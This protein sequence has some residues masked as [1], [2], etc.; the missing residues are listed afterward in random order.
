MLTKT[1]IFPS[2]GNGTKLKIQSYR[3]E[4]N[5][6][7]WKGDV[8]LSL[9][10]DIWANFYLLT[11][12]YVTWVAQVIGHDV[13]SPKLPNFLG[14]GHIRPKFAQISAYSFR[15]QI[16]MRISGQTFCFI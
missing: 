15:E 3:L 11:I 16:P 12:R 4:R 5:F 14:N 6:A 10:T 8:S 9:Y 2:N 13:P 7:F 1:I